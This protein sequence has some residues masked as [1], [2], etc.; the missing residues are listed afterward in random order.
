[1]APVYFLQSVCSLFQRPNQC[2]RVIAQ[3]LICLTLFET[4]VGIEKKCGESTKRTTGQL[5][6]MNNQDVKPL[7][8]TRVKF[9]LKRN[10]EK[11]IICRKRSDWIFTTGPHGHAPS[12]FHRWRF[13]LFYF[14]FFLSFCSAFSPLFYIRYEEQKQKHS[15]V[16]RKTI[17]A[18]PCAFNFIL[19]HL[20]I[21]LWYVNVNSV[22]DG[23]NRRNQK[24]EGGTQ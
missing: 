3:Q 18:V 23:V 13:I 2:A 10:G 11:K 19:L 24:R 17:S 15:N 14:I 5:F 7:L 8:L 6:F 20:G 22:T 16:G 9:K 21:S 1:M 12:S 4:L